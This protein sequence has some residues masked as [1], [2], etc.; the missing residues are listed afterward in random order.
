MIAI[1]NNGGHNI[2]SVKFALE[3]LGYRSVITS[4]IVEIQ[5]SDKVILPGVGSAKD[6]IKR[7]KDN[8]LIQCIK[9]LKQPVLG[10][11]LGMQLFFKFSEEGDVNLLNVINGTVEHFKSIKNRSI[12]HM[13]WNTIKKDIDHPIFYN[14]KDQDYFYF[15]HSYFVPKNAFT[16]ASCFY[17]ENFTSVVNKKNFIG[18][19]FHP[20]RS[21]VAGSQFLKNFIEITL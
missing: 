10:I 4:K 8:N 14:I 16:I 3:R 5:N 7:L 9:N 13:G 6:S 18:C 20:E 19:Q 21:G 1:V 11:C 17:E 15:V 12:P 2:S